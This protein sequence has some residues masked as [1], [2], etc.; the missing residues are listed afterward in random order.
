VPR[1]T[2]LRGGVRGFLYAP[3]RG[4]GARNA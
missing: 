3:V 4:A 1:S 2:T